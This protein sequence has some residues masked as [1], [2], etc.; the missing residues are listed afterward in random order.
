MSMHIH[1]IMYIQ[2]CTGTK[3]HYFALTGNPTSPGN[4]SVPLIPGG[5][6]S[7]CS[8]GGPGGPGVPYKN[9]GILN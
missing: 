6:G 3:K 5:P 9:K 1:N 2:K 7:P 4:P 8:P